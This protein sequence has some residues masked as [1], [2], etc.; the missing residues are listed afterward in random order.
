MAAVLLL[1]VL[2]APALAEGAAA[3]DS[4]RHL[5]L[6]GGGVALPDSGV[7]SSVNPAALA[8]RSGDLR[9]VGPRVLLVGRGPL[10]DEIL[11]SM[12]R[13]GS[14]DRIPDLGVALTDARNSLWTQVGGALRWKQFEI[15][16]EADGELLIRP[17]RSLRRW[18]AQGHFGIPPPQARLV[19]EFGYAGAVPVAYGRRFRGRGAFAGSVDAGI[20]IVPFNATYQ[21]DAFRASRRGRIVHILR[22]RSSGTLL[23]ADIGIRFAPARLPVVTVGA[24]LHG[25]RNAR[26]GRFGP[27][28]SLD[29]GAAVRGRRNLLVVADLTGIGLRGK[30]GRLSAGVE[31]PVPVSGV[32]LRA[33]MRRNGLSAGLQFGAVSVA[34]SADGAGMVR[35]GFS[36]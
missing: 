33:G 18:A 28:R 35:S 7:S 36:F 9:F 6:G 29:L 5:A 20:R 13:H 19:T 23:D 11:A 34:Y 10:D 21:R 12:I 24:V 8:A 1:P 3:G 14:F 15:G 2:Q 16:I 4:A 17:N 25:I 22:D 32:V 27:Q 30:P 31:Y 26:V